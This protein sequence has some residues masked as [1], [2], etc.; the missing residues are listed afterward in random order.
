MTV[1]E[2]KRSILSLSSGL[3]LTFPSFLSCHSPLSLSSLPSPLSPLLLFEQIHV[4]ET[5]F[6]EMRCIL[7]P[8]LVE[9][10]FTTVEKSTRFHTCKSKT[11]TSIS[12]LL[13]VPIRPQHIPN[14]LRSRDQSKVSGVGGAMKRARSDPSTSSSMSTTAGSPSC[15]MIKPSTQW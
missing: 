12:G 4:E 11:F 8:H 15:L 14:L 1:A 3:F 2:T 10:Y 13:S 7:G 6:D 5:K 9:E